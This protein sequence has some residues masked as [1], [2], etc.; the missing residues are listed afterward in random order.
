MSECNRLRPLIEGLL[1]DELSLTELH[2]LQGH[3]ST[4]PDCQALVDLHQ[5][6]DDIGDEQPEPTPADFRAM[7]NRVLSSTAGRSPTPTPLPSR[8]S[9]WWVA[10]SLVAAAATLVIG[11]TIGRISVDSSTLDDR[12]L[13]D[14]VLA[15]ANASHDLED[16]WD[17]PLSYSN[18][19]TSSVRNGQVHLDFNVCSRLDVTTNVNSSLARE[20]LTHAVL[21]SESIG[22]RLRAIEAAGNSNDPQL[23]EALAVAVENDPN[24]SV[25]IEALNALMNQV[26]TPRVET[27]LLAVLRGDESVQIRL[28]ALE[29]LVDE[30]RSIEQLSKV[31]L[32]G[33]LDSDRAVLQRAMELRND[34]ETPDWL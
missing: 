1:A 11:I 6:L 16:Y 17:S 18:V 14:T 10:G 20:L 30:Q 32:A 31:I 15:Q 8:P 27:A 5:Q 25:R 7:R 2:A 22:D 23:T 12:L 9:S 29:K 24:V 28:M 33:D 26:Q 34:G 19:N 3:L 13:L 21:D 4:C